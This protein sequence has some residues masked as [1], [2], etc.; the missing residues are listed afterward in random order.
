MPSIQQASSFEPSEILRARFCR[1]PLM[2]HFDGSRVGIIFRTFPSCFTTV[3]PLDVVAKVVGHE[4][5]VELRLSSIIT[6]RGVAMR[7]PGTRL[8]GT[9]SKNELWR[10]WWSLTKAGHINSSTY[11]DTT[12]LMEKRPIAFQW[13]LP[14]AQVLWMLLIDR[15]TQLLIWK[16]EVEVQDLLVLFLYLSWDECIWVRGKDCSFD[17][18]VPSVWASRDSV[19]LSVSWRLQLNHW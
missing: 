2:N 7:W 9:E 12:F 1:V 10:T 11:G 5:W 13:I 18:L 17:I 4:L 15:K 16:A 8:L 19:D 3:S 6:I 14:E